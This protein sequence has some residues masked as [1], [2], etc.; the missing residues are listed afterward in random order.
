MTEIKLSAVEQ[1]VLLAFYSATGGKTGDTGLDDDDLV[2][3]TGLTPRE[4]FHATW[5]LAE[6]GVVSRIGA[7]G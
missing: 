7:L 6:L 4:V 1:K 5:R 3:V 2:R